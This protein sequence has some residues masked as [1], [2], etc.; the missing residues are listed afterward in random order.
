[1]KYKQFFSELGAV[2][3][4]FSAPQPDFDRYGTHN[5]DPHKKTD[6]QCINCTNEEIAPEKFVEFAKTR[7]KGAGDITASSKEKGG[8]ALLTYH[9]FKVKAPY[10]QMVID[11]KFNIEEAE[12]ELQTHLKKLSSGSTAMKQAEFQQLVGIIE[13][14]GELI[15]QHKKLKKINEVVS[16]LEK[17]IPTS[18]DKWA[19]AKVAAR[20]K[21]K[22]YPSAY[23]NLWASKKYK[24]MGG[25][26]K[27][28]KG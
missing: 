17:N 11:G 6:G 5:P 3:Q 1:M 18:P 24:S 20:S 19:K 22:V 28:E 7:M 10:Y 14:L 8:H 4:T 27:K 26:W 9:H 16:R 2:G 12:A 25:S 13:V 23:A 15:I 21:F